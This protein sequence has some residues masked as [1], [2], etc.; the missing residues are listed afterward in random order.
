MV[1]VPFTYLPQQFSDPTDILE[2]LRRFLPTGQFTLGKPVVDFEWRFAELIGTKHAIGVGSGTD[3]LKL[4]L[5]AIGVGPGDEVITAANTFVATVGAINEVGAHAV[6]V[7]CDDSFCMDVGKVDA[8]IT[9]RTKVIIPVHLTGY[10]TDMRKLMPIAQKHGLAVVEDACQ[11]ILADIEGRK[12]GT[13]GI[14]GGFSL[15][16]LKNLN[17][18]GDGGIVVTNDDAIADKLRLLRN[19]GLLHRDHV[20]VLGYNSRLDS[21]Q[22][23]VGNWL[24]KDVHD[25]TAR[26]IENAGYYDDQ[27][28]AIPELR[29]PMRPP[30]CKRVFHLYMVFAEQRDGLLK[31][32][33]Q[34]G[35]EAKIHYPV[36]L[37]QQRGLSHLGYKPGD[38][39]VADRQAKEIISFPCH[40][41]LTRVQQDYIIATVHEFYAGGG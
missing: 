27:F 13:W 10:M 8:A 20:E 35:I 16:P 15:H 33:L 5:K 24:L 22:A 37:Y 30:D 26:R 23:I 40:Q 25:I 29:V 18:W 21:M 34:N 11:A 31:Y 17:V 39:P 12:A 1:K 9:R 28:K 41:H 14:A 6:L 3:S 38:F 2:E 32:C 7:D 19:H 4:S 36:P